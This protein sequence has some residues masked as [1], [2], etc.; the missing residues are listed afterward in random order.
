MTTKV[1]VVDDSAMSR[2]VLIRALPADWDIEIQEASDGAEAVEIVMQ[3]AVDIMFLDLT[4]PVLDGYGVLEKLQQENKT[5]LVIVVSADI[6]TDAETRVKNLG[7]AA[8]MKKP[9]QADDLLPVLI[10]NKLY[11]N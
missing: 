10:A 7:A 1:L 3:N 11:G 4:M 6:Q 9:T 8:F 5:P 2:K